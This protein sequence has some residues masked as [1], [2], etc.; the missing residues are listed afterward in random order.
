MRSLIKKK[1]FL[2]YTREAFILPIN[3]VL[4]AVIATLLTA[5]LIIETSFPIKWLSTP[6]QIGLFLATALEMAYLAFAPGNE[7]FIRAIN[8]KNSALIER[9]ET[10]IQAL[11]TLEKLSQPN[12]ERY[13]SFLKKKMQVLYNLKNNHL[14]SDLFLESYSHKLNQ[15]DNAYLQQIRSLDQIHT[16]NNSAQ[17]EPQILTEIK[18]LQAEISQ[19]TSEKVKNAKKQR[20]ELM[21]KRID[22]HLL[23]KESKELAATQIANLEDTISYLLDQSLVLSEQE[24][25]Q[26]IDTVISE[27]ETN[28]Q[29]IKELNNLQGNSSV[30]GSS[31]YESS[32]YS[33]ELNKN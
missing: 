32:N 18:A 17:E 12:S 10:Q 27:S 3:L 14:T 4:L 31:N 6:I 28:I 7:R 13:L 11:T 21:K 29:T 5:M 30:Y 33:S 25:T 16:Y 15:L 19:A 1:P 26:L 2:N 24:L 23:V 20:L 9:T 22:Q 8:T